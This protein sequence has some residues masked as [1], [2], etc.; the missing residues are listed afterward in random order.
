[1]FLTVPSN[2]IPIYISATLIYLL[3][4]SGRLLN[5]IYFPFTMSMEEITQMI[6]YQIIGATLISGD[7]SATAILDGRYHGLYGFGVK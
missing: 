5:I 4:E 6:S 3:I 1:M 7:F 2:L